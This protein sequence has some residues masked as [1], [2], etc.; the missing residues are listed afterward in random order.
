MKTYKIPKFEVN[1]TIEP[2][3]LPWNIEMCNAPNMWRI[4]KGGGAVVAVI[5]TGCDVNHQEFENRIVCPRNFTTIGAY[6]DVVDTN[7]HG[8]HVAGIIAGKTVG[9]APAARIMPLKVFGDNKV[10]DN[11]YEAMLFILKYNAIMAAPRDRVACVNCSFG[12]GFYDPMM[13]YAIRK[14]VNNGVMVVVA[15]GNQGDGKADTEEIFSYPAYIHEC[16]TIG[17][18]NQD[19]TQ[20]KYSNSFDGIDLAAP[21][22]YIYSAWPGSAYQTLSGTSMAAPHVSGAAALLYDAWRMRELDYPTEEQAYKL[23]MKHFRPLEISHKLVGE[24][25]L[26]LT[27]L[28]GRW[29]LWRVQTGAFY[30]FAGAVQLEAEINKAGFKTY[31][32]KY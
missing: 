18:L 30:N 31:I 2:A 6:N 9:I 17:A 23:L 32:P 14:L 21:G 1:Q 20:A 29:P 5:D 24:G 13:A 22:T 15:A 27:W 8:T 3:G 12:G 7:G 26:D 28:M 10:N 16:V 4:T 19:C 25:L 11:I